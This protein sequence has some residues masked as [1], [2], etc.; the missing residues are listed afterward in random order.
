MK[1]GKNNNKSL[2]GGTAMNNIIRL[3]Q[4][5]AYKTGLRIK[6]GDEDYILA[7]DEQ[8][9]IGIKRFAYYS[10]YILR[11]T[12][13]PQAYDYDLGAYLIAFTTEETNLEPGT[14]FYDVA[15]Q[16]RDGELEKI[17]GCTELEVIRSVVRRD[18]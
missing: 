15:L 13:P 1:G 6:D 12:V 18:E 4:N 2:R 9:V 7:D 5:R 11:K 16:R 3:A 10:G 14:Y 8:L 17:I